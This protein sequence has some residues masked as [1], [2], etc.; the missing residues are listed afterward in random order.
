MKI[1]Y[2]DRCKK[3]SIYIKQITFPQ[4]DEESKEYDV[5][6]DCMEIFDRFWS[7]F[8]YPQEKEIKESDEK[9]KKLLK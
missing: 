4:N 9:M 7:K 1:T 8:L 3:E 2:C 5:C 6:P